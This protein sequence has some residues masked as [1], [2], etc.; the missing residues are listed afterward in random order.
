MLVYFKSFDLSNDFSKTVALVQPD[1][2]PKHV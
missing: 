2:P 1:N